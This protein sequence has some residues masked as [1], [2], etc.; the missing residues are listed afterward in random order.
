MADKLPLVKNKY[1]SFN[2]PAWT[3]YDEAKIDQRDLDQKVVDARD[4][5]IEELNARISLAEKT[6][7]QLNNDADRAIA[8]L[9]ARPEITQGN[10]KILVYVLTQALYNQPEFYSD[11]QEIITL[12]RPIADG[13][14]EQ[15]GK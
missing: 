4:A 2:S 1:S 9:A 11:I 15:E 7:I 6:M 3:I 8:Q 13:I 12:H 14:A 5:E 10:T